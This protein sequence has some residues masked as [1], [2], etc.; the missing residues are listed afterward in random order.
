MKAASLIRI[1]AWAFLSAGPVLPCLSSTQ[2]S[3]TVPDSCVRYMNNCKYIKSI[4]YRRFYIESIYS[5]TSGG[6][7]EGLL[8]NPVFYARE[9]NGRMILDLH[10][11]VNESQVCARPPSTAEP[12][13]RAGFDAV[14]T[15]YPGRHMN[16]I[17]SRVIFGSRT[18][19]LHVV[20]FNMPMFGPKS[21]RNGP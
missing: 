11:V 13:L 1:H 9:T 20:C 19:R 5:S 12:M 7:L 18:G 14:L 15:E 6:C 10:I 17:P 2:P 16:E 3:S 8:R 4:Y 21:G